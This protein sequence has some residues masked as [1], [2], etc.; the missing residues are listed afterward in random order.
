MGCSGWSYSDWRGLVYPAKLPQRRWFEHYSSRFDTVEINNTFYRLPPPSTVEAW[1][2]QAPNGFVYALKV[3]AFGTHRM[4]LRDAASWLPNH[5]DRARR[6]GPALGPSL[7]QLPPRWKRNL[8]RLEEFL[9]AAPDTMRWAVELREP[10]WLHDD[11]FD[12]LARH[13]VA[14]CLHDLLANHPWELTADWTYLRFHGPEA[15]ERKYWGRYSA[16]R[17]SPVADRLGALVGEGHDVYAYFNN[18]HQA[19]AVADAA[20]LAQRLSPGPGTDAEPPGS[21]SAVETVTGLK[22]ISQVRNAR[23]VADRLST[24]KLIE[25]R[26]MPAKPN[27]L[28]TTEWVADHLR[29]PDV[30]IVEV[31]EDASAYQT[32]HIPGAVGFDWRADFQDPVRRTFLGRE[33]FSALMDSAG[34]SRDHHVVLYG[35]SNNWFAAYAYWYFKIYGHDKVSLMDGGRKRWEMQHRDLTSDKTDRQASRGY[36]AKEANASIRARRDQVLSDFVGAPSGKAMVDVRSPEEFRGEKLAPEHLPGESA[37]VPGHIP[38]AANVPWSK[39]VD[40]DTGAFLPDEK[41]KELYAA[42]GVTSDKEVVAY[43]RIGERSAHTW[44]ALSELLGFDKVRN[45]DG[46]WTEYGSLVDVPVEK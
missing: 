39:A 46:S 3:G 29:D 21:Q 19:A 35:G 24:T 38:G 44:F 26:P 14:L 45:Y 22:L 43:C 30:V 32:S 23:V 17:L 1:A 28:V 12:L 7:V 42:Q 16:D 18:D 8:E 6:L 13:G 11:V 4:K 34:T 40:P 33:G 31:D 25:E 2:A 37:M 10:S 9:S 15:L 27:A 36:Q 5:V 41:L 20:W